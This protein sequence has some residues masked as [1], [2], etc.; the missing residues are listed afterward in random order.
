MQLL[1]SANQLKYQEPTNHSL[2]TAAIRLY[3]SGINKQLV[4]ETTGHCSTEG[5][6]T[7]KRTSETQRQALSD[8]LSAKRICVQH[9]IPPVNP[10]KVFQFRN[11]LLLL[12]SQTPH[13]PLSQPHLFSIHAHLS[14]SILTPVPSTPTCSTF[15]PACSL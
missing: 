1:A 15:T 13:L 6:R 14:P 12:N 5:V 11:S 7:Y 4:M 8:I 3:D 9:P 10:L 2:L